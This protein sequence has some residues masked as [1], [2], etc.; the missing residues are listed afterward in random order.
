MCSLMVGPRWEN[1]VV[2]DLEAGGAELLD[3][4]GERPALK[5]TQLT[6][7]V[8]HKAWAVWSAS[9]RWRTLPW[10]A[11]CTFAR[12]AWRD[13]PLVEL[14][15]DPLAQLGLLQVA[16]DEQ[17]LDQPPVVLKGPGQGV[18][19]GGGLQLGQ[20]QRRQHRPLV[21]GGAHPQQVTSS[22]AAVSVSLRRNQA[23]AWA[24]WS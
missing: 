17:G 3:R 23:V 15:A 5:A 18:L 4:R 11:K 22:M 21:D 14:A 24:T 2:V 1:V 13:S 9:C 20:Q 19:A 7:S 6:T 8:R 12:S 10:W 16:H